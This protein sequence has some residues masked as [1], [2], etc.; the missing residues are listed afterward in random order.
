MS[1]AYVNSDVLDV[2]EEIYPAPEDTDKVI[3]ITK[4]L[5]TTSLD[6]ITKK[7]VS[8]IRPG[9]FLVCYHG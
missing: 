1:S 2:E 6:V 5:D 9:I 4:S 7:L 8:S 3:E